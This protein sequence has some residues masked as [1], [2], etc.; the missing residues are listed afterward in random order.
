MERILEKLII[1]D[2]EKWWSF[3]HHL[4]VVKIIKNVDFSSVL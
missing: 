4:V 3:D 1:R 2:G